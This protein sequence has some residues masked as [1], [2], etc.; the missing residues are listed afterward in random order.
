MDGGATSIAGVAVGVVI[1]TQDG[2][3]EVANGSGVSLFR[4]KGL[5]R[6]IW[7]LSDGGHTISELTDLLCQQL[8]T[9][10]KPAMQ[11]ELVAILSVLVKKSAIVANWNPLYKLQAN[12]EL[13]KADEGGME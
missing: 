2:E 6:T 3:I 11:K 9:D 7:L 1:I 4:L 5:G 12:Q 8:G 10:N 13:K